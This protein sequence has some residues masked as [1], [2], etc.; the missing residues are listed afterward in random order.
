MNL[1]TWQYA[2]LRIML[3]AALSGVAFAQVRTFVSGV[4]DDANPC[5]RTAPCKTF[6]GAYSKTAA[7]GEIDVL[8]P[9]GFGAVTLAKSITLDASG[10]TAGVLISAG[11]GINVNNSSGNP[12]SV[13]LRGLDV[14]GL[15]N[16]GTGINILGASPVNV[17]IERMQIYGFALNGINI[18]PG[19]AGKANVTVTDSRISECGS[20]NGINAD[21]S[22]GAVNLTLINTEVQHC[23]TGLNVLGGAR[24]NARNSDFSGNATGVMVSGTSEAFLDSGTV[25]NCSTTGVNA[26]TSGA[27]VRLSNMTIADN[28][29]GLTIA[30]GGLVV[31]FG[32]N[33]IK[34]NTTG[35]LPT[36]TVFV[37]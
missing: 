32:N 5:S 6:A 8:D 34:A 20:N 12:I 27:T 28:V 11:N 1:G 30:T 26:A 35:A 36:S 33:R 22:N 18:V 10:A 3:A 7:G 2:A 17:H 16:G 37:N 13:T 21:A 23:G 14:N 31:S 15:S 25:A 19:A 29:A 4:G 9:G 24:V